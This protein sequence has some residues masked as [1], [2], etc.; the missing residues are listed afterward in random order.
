MWA[1]GGGG[2]VSRGRGRGKQGVGAW[3][4]GGRGRGQ[5]GEGGHG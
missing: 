3:V 4:A 5:Q 2:V 1:T